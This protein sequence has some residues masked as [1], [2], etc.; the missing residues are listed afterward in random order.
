MRLYAARYSSSDTSASLIEQFDDVQSCGVDWSVDDF[1]V[2]RI[3]ITIKANGPY[4]AFDRYSNHHG[5]RLALYTEDLKQPVSGRIY[6]VEWLAGDLIKYIAYGPNFDMERAYIVKRFVSTDTITSAITYIASKI[7][8]CNSDT[9]KIVTNAT[10][11]DGWNPKFPA[12]SY[13]SEAI[14]DLLDMSDSSNRLYDFRMI[15]EPL[16][17][18]S[19]KQYTPHYTYRNSA[20][21]PD[22]VISREDLSAGGLRLSRNIQDFANIVRV[23][24]G[25]VE[26]TS[27]A[28]TATSMTDAAATFI[29]DGVKPGD[30]ITNL[31]KGGRT[32]IVTVDSE[33]K[34]THEGWRPKQR[35]VA[36]GG[37]T[38]TLD[39][40]EADFIVDGIIVGDILTNLLDSSIVATDG[41]GTITGV[42]AT[43][44]TIAG[45]MSGGKS[46]NATERY[47]ISGPMVATD[48]YSIKTAAQTKFAEY[49]ID[50]GTLWDK[51]LAVYESG[52]NETQARQYA[53]ALATVNPQQYQSFVISAPFIRD[54]NGARRN[55]LDM[56]SYGGG[57]IQI[58]DL[59]PS[60][61]QF[62]NALN[63]LTTFWIT[64]MSY[65]YATNKLTVDV[66]TL[67][68][69]LDARLRRA[70]ILRVQ[71]VQRY[72]R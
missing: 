59:Y 57:Y 34:V 50:N 63:S 27:T 70:K 42:A 64:S 72:G 67:S 49:Q 52:M 19:L 55:L 25:V 31:T 53:K 54:G 46:N 17:G 39:D 29:S 15:D 23:W 35:G 30:T 26:G 12:G 9:S 10:T 40:T 21:S 33:T 22:W 3:E 56:L 60:A 11:L 8:V 69:R 28:V 36:T 1:G 41:I 44:L 68:R 6:E 43:Q 32:K 37:S 45:T 14:P 51:E 18:T 5:Q 4:D 58:S 62:S 61:A 13:P 20:A 24:Y 65:D 47:E 7:P 16:S 71:Q 48:T 38:T 66:D 2:T